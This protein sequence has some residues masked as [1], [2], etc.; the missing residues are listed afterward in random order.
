MGF[1][2][3]NEDVIVAQKWL[4]LIRPRASL[5]TDVLPSS[6]SDRAPRL[7]QE[8]WADYKRRKREES[9]YAPYA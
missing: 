5:V 1:A 4:G 8:C 9:E 3:R 6:L 2:Y 7:A